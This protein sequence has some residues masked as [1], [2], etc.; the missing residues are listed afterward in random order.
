MSLAAQV[1]ALMTRELRALDA[2]RDL[3]TAEKAAVEAKDGEALQKAA[4]T[5]RSLIDQVE[6][7]TAE[8]TRLLA[9]RGLAADRAGFD[10][11]LAQLDSR[12][13]PAAQALWASV[14][15]GLQACQKQNQVNGLLLDASVRSTQE[16]LAILL[17]HPARDTRTYDSQGAVDKSLGTRCFAKA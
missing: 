11:L 5:K 7:L 3:L 9:G 10:A 8:R 4:T 17:G 2:L 16:T 1:T 15:E 12:E 13:R 6:S 14:L